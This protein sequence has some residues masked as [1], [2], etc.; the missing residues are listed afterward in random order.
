ML[1]LLKMDLPPLGVFVLISAIHVISNKAVLTF[2]GFVYPAVFL[3]F[4]LSWQALCAAISLARVVLRTRR[5][6]RCTNQ[7]LHGVLLILP[8]ITLYT[9]TGSKALAELPVPIFLSL[10]CAVPL[11]SWGIEAV[12][13]QE[14]K[15]H[16]RC[17][18]QLSIFIM[19]IFSVAS[20]LLSVPSPYSEGVSWMS[21]HV[22]ASVI[23][24]LLE[25]NGVNQCVKANAPLR[26]LTYHCSVLILLTSTS[27]MAGDYFHVFHA[28]HFSRPSFW[29]TFVASGASIAFLATRGSS[30]FE[31]SLSR[32]FT[33]GLS[34]FLLKL[35]EDIP[36]EITIWMVLLFLC[37]LK[38]NW[39]P[40]KA[41]P[42]CPHDKFRSM[43]HR[44][45][46]SDCQFQA[47]I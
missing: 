7:L 3:R 28:P 13:L 2:E 4:F 10:Q 40:P 33:A 30:P 37:L 21:V 26:D 17:L 19:A 14:E 47:I 6:T 46:L 36:V 44:Q 20:I 22:L 45:N 35:P 18:S 34:F 32:V 5:Q 12:L 23:V 15:G 43:A 29:L 38:L 11:F 9:Y 8:L 39:G 1:C 25:V 31:S 27:L 42:V 24:R 41:R 16:Q